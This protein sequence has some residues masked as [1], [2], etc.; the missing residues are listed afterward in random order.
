[1]RIGGHA[2]HENAGS[3]REFLRDRFEKGW[4]RFVIDME[5]CGGIDSTFI[6]ILYRLAAK[7][8]EREGDGSVEVLH[9][10]ERNERSIRK[11]GLDNLIRIESNGG[12]WVEEK[13]LVEENL[14][15]PPSDSPESSRD[16]AEM[17]LE[18]HEALIE[19]NE[20][21]RSRF[22]DVVDFIR[23]ELDSQDSDN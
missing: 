6:G 12:Q 2:N 20:E 9:P 14:K 22:R 18:A 15:H 16:H 13:A 21:N 3:I 5:N 1:V 10:S 4:N 17:V 19:A 8:D 23:E 11:L 7:L